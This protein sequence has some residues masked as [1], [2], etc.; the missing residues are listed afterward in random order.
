M[1]DQDYLN[2]GVVKIDGNKVK[3]YKSTIN[4]QTIG[5][6]Q[7]VTNA[8]WAGGELNVT[9]ANGTVRR[10]RSTINYQTI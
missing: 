1:W 4:Y 8:S 5:V 10:Y 7:P 9:L 6:G 3:V 2:F